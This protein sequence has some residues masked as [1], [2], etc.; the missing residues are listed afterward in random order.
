MFTSANDLSLNRLSAPLVAA[1]SRDAVPLRLGLSRASGGTTLIDAGV[2]ATGGIEAGRRI[3]EI[4]LAGLGTVEIG[5]GGAESVWPWV[6]TVRSSQPVLAC[7]GSQYAGWALKHGE[8]KEGFFALGSGPGRAL[9]AKEDLFAELGYRD[10][11]GETVLVLEV[12]EPPPPPLLA[13]IA[14]DCGVGADRLTVIL[15]PT[16]SLAGSVQIAARSLEVALHKAHSVKFP[17]NRIIDGMGVAPVPPPVPG[18]V[19]AMGRTNDAILYGGAVQ[20]FVT[21]KEAEAEAL[22]EQLPSATSRD[23]GRPFAEIFAAYQGDFYQIDPLLFS[24]GLVQV[25]A[26]ESGRTFRRG[27]L[28][29]GLLARSFGLEAA[30]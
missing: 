15:T 9:A 16:T 8:G 17:L 28:D 14:A 30:Q 22:A 21:G 1:L 29:A 13:R 11:H 7:L 5:P 10:R 3:A 23:Y 19:E 18:F 25:T 2:S 12:N 20:L 27:R 24:P 4:C 6:V 26:L